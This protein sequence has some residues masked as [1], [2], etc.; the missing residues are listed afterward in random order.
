M[1]G[2][3]D[4]EI[5]PAIGR[6][7]ELYAHGGARSHLCGNGFRC[8]YRSCRGHDLRDV[9]T[10]VCRHY[11]GQ[12]LADGPKTDDGNLQHLRF[13]SK[14]GSALTLAGSLS[15]RLSV[16]GDAKAAGVSP[17]TGLVVDDALG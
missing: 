15:D 1:A 2:A 10:N 16:I 12:L 11:S 14:R 9:Q 7:V 8:C 13:S 17:D 5:R 6:K 3:L 4:Y